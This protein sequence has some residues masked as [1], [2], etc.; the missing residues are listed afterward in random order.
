MSGFMI[1]IA[2]AIIQIASMARDYVV[3]NHKC[4]VIAYA[5]YVFGLLVAVF[6]YYYTP[7]KRK[8]IIESMKS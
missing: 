2:G 6:G 8:I 7:P 1:I 5:L 4:E 3:C